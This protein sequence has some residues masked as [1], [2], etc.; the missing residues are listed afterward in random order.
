MDNPFAGLDGRDGFHAERVE[1]GDAYI[2]V[3][4]VAYT[5]GQQAEA[6]Q[7]VREW[8]GPSAED[9]GAA[10]RLELALEA[11]CRF[12]NTAGGW[13][14]LHRALTL[15]RLFAPGGLDFPGFF[16]ADHRTTQGGHEHL[17]V[18]RDQTD[19]AVLW[20]EE[21][22]EVGPP[23]PLEDI[24]DEWS[25]LEAEAADLYAAEGEAP[26][27][28]LQRLPDPGPAGPAG[29]GPAEPDAR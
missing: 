7:L 29:P 22:G 28:L 16:Y 4:L 25:E 14:E 9:R 18:R 11:V 15:T 26:S 23:R 2:G 12:L 19:Q 1:K 6:S 27:H 8:R 24:L 13:E 21:V 5:G 3:Y 10:V 20:I 17:F